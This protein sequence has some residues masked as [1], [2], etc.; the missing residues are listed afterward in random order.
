MHVDASR[1]FYFIFSDRAARGGGRV[2]CQTCSFSFFPCSP[3]HEER[4]WPPYTVVFFVLA[5]NTLNVRNNNLQPMILPRRF[6][7]FHPDWGTLRRSR[8]VHIFL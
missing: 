8:C 1:D 2:C 5:T 3:D 6:D 4:D 7:I